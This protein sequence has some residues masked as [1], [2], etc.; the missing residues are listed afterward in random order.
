MIPQKPDSLAN[1]IQ[2]AMQD[3]GIEV[4]KKV[5]KRRP[6]LD[7]NAAVIESP[8]QAMRGSVTVEGLLIK[9][10]SAEEGPG[11]FTLRPLSYSK[12]DVNSVSNGT[13][14]IENDAVLLNR[15]NLTERFTASTDGIRQDFIIS[16]SPAGAGKLSLVLE[17]KGAKAAN[18]LQGVSVIMDN[19]RK[20]EYHR[21]FITDALGKTFPG[22]M[23]AISEDLI[24]IWV[25]DS[26]AAYPLTI[27]PT[28]TD[29]NWVAITG[30]NGS[31]YA[32]AVSGSN[33][34][35]G[36]M[37]TTAG[38]VSATNIAKW[39]GT[40][41]STLGS[42]LSGT[43]AQV[44]AMA[45]SGTT[46]LFVSGNFTTAGGK[47]SP[48]LAKVTNLGAVAVSATAGTT[49]GSYCTLKEAFDAINVGT[50]QGT[51]TVTISASTTETA[52]A[53]LNASGTGTASNTSSYTIVSG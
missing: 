9:S 5:E 22:E 39:D 37:F 46:E 35:V 3:L 7:G 6:F 43:F 34:Y 20:L 33:L 11:N 4:D 19:G 2:I 25:H 53:V 14:S 26:G 45:M 47:S 24:C 51:V 38:G 13:I 32:I 48:Y 1:T 41:W 16:A 21:L 28:I 8:Y 50:N 36:G 18:S 10:T 27:D 30:F 15:G 29:A 23:K 44:L 49:T 52:S 12:G 31:V 42:G 40:T 17:L